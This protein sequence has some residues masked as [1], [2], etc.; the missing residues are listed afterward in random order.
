MKRLIVLL[1]ILNINAAYANENEAIYFMGIPSYITATQAVTAVSK[2]ALNRKWTVSNFEN[3]ILRIEL[4][5]RSYKAV[6]KFS[7]SD[8]VIRYSDSTTY[9]Y[10]DDDGSEE[11]WIPK[12]APSNW[13]RNLKKDV[14]MH[15]A[16]NTSII[17]IREKLS[18]EDMTKK[19]ESLKKLYN[20]KLITKKE[21]ELKKK[22]IMSRY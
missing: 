21:Y 4:N 8:N 20:K 12:P 7:F 15:F 17:Y 10:D 14:N 13:I 5:H 2:A 1:F 6:L 11:E 16:R 19:L 22:E 3:N 18:D 9:T